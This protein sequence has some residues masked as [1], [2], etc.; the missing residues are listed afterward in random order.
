[1]TRPR[2]RTAV[3]EPQLLPG[4]AAVEIAVQ[5]DRAA[6]RVLNGTAEAGDHAGPVLDRNDAA[7]YAY[8]P[9]R[10]GIDAA[11]MD[12]D[13]PFV[14]GDADGLAA[15]LHHELAVVA[16]ELAFDGAAVLDDH[17]AV[18]DQPALGAVVP[19][20]LKAEPGAADH[21]P[22]PDGEGHALLHGEGHAAIVREMRLVKEDETFFGHGEILRDADSAD[23]LRPI[24]RVAQLRL[25]RDRKAQPLRGKGRGQQRGQQAQRQQQTQDT[26]FHHD[27]P[28]CFCGAFSTVYYFV[29]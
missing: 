17:R 7:V 14:L 21:S 13:G 25:A 11:G 22:F 3:A 16:G 12:G 24:Q 26:L 18:V 2:H 28:F 10:G 20:P 19:V 4:A 29:I 23:G 6:R 8:V 15:L 9:L 5:Q 1:M 27:A